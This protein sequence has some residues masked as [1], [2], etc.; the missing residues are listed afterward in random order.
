MDLSFCPVLDELYKKRETVGRSGNLFAL[1]SG[2]S[3]LNNL[4][5]LRRLCLEVK[6]ERTL[7]VG[8]ACG[9]SALTFASSHRDLGR[10]P[11][12]QHV[13][14]DGFQ[15]EGYDDVGRMQLERAELQDYVEV[16][17]SLS[18][19]QLAELARSGDRFGVIYVDGSHRFEDV[20]VDFYFA[21]T[22]LEIGGYILFDDSSD[23]EV[24]KVVKFIQ[25]NL[26]HSFTQIPVHYYRDETLFSKIKLAIAERMH[27]TQ[28]TIFRKTLDGDRPGSQRM[29]AF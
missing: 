7:E 22:L 27:R 28:L 21:R 2:L 13:A 29:V 12:R 18:C 17:E 16:H 20:F 11:S 1:T 9:G 26:R 5:V 19:Y 25:S 8:M 14:I 24:A 4:S 23:P 15:R 3:T 10:A 6:P